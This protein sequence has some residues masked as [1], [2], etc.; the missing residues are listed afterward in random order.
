MDGTS[1]DHWMIP[2]SLV[3][4]LSFLRMRN[5]VSIEDYKSEEKGILGGRTY[6]REVETKILEVTAVEVLG[7]QSFVQWTIGRT[8]KIEDGLET[9][10]CCRFLIHIVLLA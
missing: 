9:L 10:F 2:A 5:L 8:E 1:L 6:W 4:L 7:G 3:D